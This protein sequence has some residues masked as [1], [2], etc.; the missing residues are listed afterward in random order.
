M[1]ELLP[2]EKV[3]VRNAAEK[4]KFPRQTVDY[5]AMYLGLLNHLRA[6]I[7]KDIDA[8][9]AA[10]SA[11]PGL[12]TAHNAEHFDEV[13][14]YAGSLL[15]VETGDENVSLE[16]YEIYILLVA[17]RIHDAGNIH[18]RE[19]HEKKCFSILRNCG[20][21][22]GD[23]DSEKKVIALIA[24]AHGGKTTAGNKDTISEL[25]DKEPLG[26]FFIRSRLIASIVRFADE[27]C[28]SRSRAANYLLTYGSIP[29]HS[30]LFHKYAAA[31]SANVVSHKD[32]RLT[33]VYKVKLDDTSRPWGC[34]ITGSKTESYLID[35]IL[36]R[37][38]K[39]DRERRYC[40]R[41][42]RDIYTIDS[43]RA[44]IDVIDNNVE[45]IKTIAVPE[46]YDSGY[47]DDHSGHLKEELKEFCG[48]AFY[49]SLS[50]QSVG[51]PT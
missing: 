21:A 46:L 6:N 9:L 29:T 49:Q 42:S 13:V 31:I 40:N 7:Y 8:A 17:I 23:D 24:Q 32:R 12:Y 26:K 45:T 34:A 37:L 30:E 28:E 51:E 10:N 15:G 4:S 47:P 2:L 41:F 5:A 14:H 44:T 38:E 35:E 36:E 33:L 11:T 25:K 18:G 20:A 43:I 27:I 1:T 3:F 50:Q 19:D 39:M 16:P 22:S 48:P